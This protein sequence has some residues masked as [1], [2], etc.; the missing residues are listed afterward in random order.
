MKYNLQA[1]IFFEINTKMLSKILV[2]RTLGCIKRIMPQDKVELVPEWKFVFKHHRSDNVTDQI[3]IQNKK[4]R[5]K[6]F[7]MSIYDDVGTIQHLFKLK[8]LSKLEIERTSQ[9]NKEL[10]VMLLWKWRA[11]ISAFLVP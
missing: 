10:C 4:G 3:K 9:L 1:N 8:S 2:S 6:L 7:F 11:M 5:E